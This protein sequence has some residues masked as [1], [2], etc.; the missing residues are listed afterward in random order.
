MSSPAHTME[1]ARINS[2]Y[3]TTLES[4]SEEEVDNAGSHS[5][6]NAEGRQMPASGLVAVKSDDAVEVG[7]ENFRKRNEEETTL[8]EL[9][10]KIKKAGNQY[11][12]PKTTLTHWLGTVRRLSLIHI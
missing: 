2:V 1:G 8:I 10:N 12:K 3:K 5:A 9:Y 4:E 6:E 11:A 7:I